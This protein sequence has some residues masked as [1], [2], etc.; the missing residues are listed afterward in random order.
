METATVLVL[1]LPRTSHVNPRSHLR[2]HAQFLHVIKGWVYE[3]IL[4]SFFRELQSHCNCTS[5]LRK[6]IS[7]GKN[8]LE[9]LLAD[10]ET[11][12]EMYDS[13]SLAYRICHQITLNEACPAHS[14]I[15][16]VITTNYMEVRSKPMFT[17]QKVVSLDNIYLHAFFPPPSRA[18]NCQNHHY[19]MSKISTAPQE[20]SPM[21]LPQTNKI[22]S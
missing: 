5:G 13:G 19:F 22:R 3:A 7:D 12:T 20:S 14:Y 8:H 9:L 16:T 10:R 18:A 15:D 6:C 1:V 21:P 2:C 17:H 4:L 11:E